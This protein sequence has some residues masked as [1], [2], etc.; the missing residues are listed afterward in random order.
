MKNKITISL[1]SLLLIL[2]GFSM[3]PADDIS[4]VCL[5]AE[6]KKLYLLIMDYR[7]TMKLPNIPTSRSLTYVAQAH[8][9]DLVENTPEKGKC[10]MHSWSNKGNWKACCYT[11]DHKRPSCMWGKPRELTDYSG[12]GYEIA[13]GYDPGSSAE[14]D[15]SAEDA[16]ELWKNSSAHNAIIINKGIWKKT[17]WKA[18]GIGIY[19]GAATVWF[20]KVDD[21]AGEAISCVD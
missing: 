1:L 20:G 7:K 14:H 21:L 17:K 2:S 11:A 5:S 12:D 4:K 3:T 9:K 15:L 8:S 6:E 18:I 10:N 16:L 19:K 13:A